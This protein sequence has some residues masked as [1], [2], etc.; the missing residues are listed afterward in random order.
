MI[1]R[2]LMLNKVSGVTQRQRM[3]NFADLKSKMTDW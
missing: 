1:A 2:A 3:T